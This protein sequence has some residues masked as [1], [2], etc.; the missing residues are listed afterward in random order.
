MKFMIAEMMNIY[1]FTL[2]FQTH[3][4]VEIVF[5]LQCMMRSFDTPS[6]QP[7]QSAVRYCV[8]PSYLTC[9]HRNEIY[10]F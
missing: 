3:W 7:I 4:N 5:Y 8:W 2:E 6:K 1:Q 9:L 10:R